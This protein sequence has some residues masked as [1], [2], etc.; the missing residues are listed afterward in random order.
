MSSISTQA[1]RGICATPKALRVCGPFSPKTSPSNGEA[2]LAT[3]CCSVNVGALPGPRFAILF[4]DMARNESQISC[5]HNRNKSRD[6]WFD[7]WQRDV[8]F[9]QAIVDRH[10]LLLKV[11]WRPRHSDPLRLNSR[12]VL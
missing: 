8:Q 4:G 10:A 2:P 3:R 1:P 11:A 5:A 9:F 7:D 6:R 12:L